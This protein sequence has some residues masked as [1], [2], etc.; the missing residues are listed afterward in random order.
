MILTQQS[1][2]DLIADR[3]SF[4]KLQEPAPQAALL[5]KILKASLRVPDHH[6]QQPW[7]FLLIQGK[8][9]NALGDLFA[10]SLSLDSEIPINEEQL[11][12]AR[13]KAQR[14]PLIIAGIVKHLNHEKVPAIEEN[15]S[16]AAV[17]HNLGLALYSE[18]FGSVWRTG[19]FCYHPYIL[20][21]LGLASNEE[22]LGYLYVGT[23]ANRNRSIPE[24][25][26]SDFYQ[27]W[28]SN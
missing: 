11:D 16:A 24:L 9:R 5:D 14:A 12:K 20:K 21:G 10:E 2:I 22:L 13:A 4:P 3:R 28:P 17:F 19:N 8:A 7:R 1:I 6:R 25:Q 15:L 26:V 18:G 23:P 27:Q